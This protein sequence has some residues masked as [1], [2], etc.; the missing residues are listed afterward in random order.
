MRTK[1]ML[2][3]QHRA[4]NGFDRGRG[5]SRISAVYCAA[6]SSWGRRLAW[7]TTHTPDHP[8]IARLI[9]ATPLQRMST[10]TAANAAQMRSI[11]GLG[12]CHVF[13]HAQEKCGFLA[14][15]ITASRPWRSPVVLRAA[16]TRTVSRSRTKYNGIKIPDTCGQEA[17][18]PFVTHVGS[19]NELRDGPTSSPR[20]T[21]KVFDLVPITGTPRGENPFFF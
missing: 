12:L 11:R 20:R 4:G 19:G 5:T 17:S 13:Y 21:Q 8:S 9:E 15:R 18:F 3:S 2:W 16:R 10:P 7:C 14:R 1:R 6:Y